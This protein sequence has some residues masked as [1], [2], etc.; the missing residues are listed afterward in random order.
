[1]TTDERTVT[2]DDKGEWTVPVLPVGNNY[3][4]TYELTGFKR[5]VRTNVAVEAAIPRT[6]TDRLEIGEVGATVTVEG[7]AP[8]ITPETSTTFR[9]LS[10]DSCFSPHFYAQFTPLLSTEQRYTD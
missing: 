2:T 3:E 6:L 5:L 9:Q 7:E 4:V 8:L 1:M 10:A